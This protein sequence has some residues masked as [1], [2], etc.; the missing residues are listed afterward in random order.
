MPAASAV[1]TISS[2]FALPT[3]GAI[4]EPEETLAGAW[5]AWA[6]TLVPSGRVGAGRGPAEALETPTPAM[7]AVQAADSSARGTSALARAHV[8]PR[9]RPDGFDI[10]LLSRVPG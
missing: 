4:A 9:V 5:I 3:P 7:L 6:G 2:A 10:R 1:A 8:A